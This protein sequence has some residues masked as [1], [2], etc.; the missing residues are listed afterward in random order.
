MAEIINTSDQLKISFDILARS[1]SDTSW[2]VGAMAHGLYS[3]KDN[4]FYSSVEGTFQI[5]EDDLSQLAKQ[6]KEFLGVTDGSKNST[7]VPVAEPS[8]E[9]SFERVPHAESYCRLISL[10]IDLKAVSQPRTP[11]AY[12]E[13]R[14][15]V[16]MHTT[17]SR[18]KEFGLQVL[19]EISHARKPMC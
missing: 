4:R 1:D 17:K 2:F 7:F 8:F 11:I 16:R 3:E 5:Y 15:I 13:N 14:I 6:L 10:A 12:G 9:I 18:L 19:K